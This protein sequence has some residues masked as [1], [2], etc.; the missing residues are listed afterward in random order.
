MQ[1]AIFSDIHGNLP[2][3]ESV[4]N[5]IET[6]RVDHVYC[7]GDLVGYAPYPN[8][9]I[10]LVRRK[11][12]PTVMGNYDEGVGS[13]RD[14]CGCAYRLPDEKRLGVLSFE[15]TKSHVT[16]ENKAFLRSL[17]REIRFEAGRRRFLLVHGSPRR[18]NEYLF[19]DRPQSSFK[20]LAEAIHA[21]VLAFGHTHRPYTK[22]VE[23]VLFVNVGSAGKPKD[24]DP[25][26]CYAL[27]Q[28][29]NGK[30]EATFQRVEYDV[31]R[32]AHAIRHSDLPDQF[33]EQLERGGNP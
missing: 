13:D 30:L 33:A 28:A 18:I 4:L 15:W 8:E 10:D 17:S 19:E 11:G 31:A 1:I 25:R 26:S 27:I 23:G 20:R 32:A 9:V 21:D 12:V 24:G 3:L 2:A 14:D 5:D 16:P 6:R 22:E 29:T 7:L